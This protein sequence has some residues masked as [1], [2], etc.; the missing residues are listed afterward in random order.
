MTPR[1]PPK[2]F[3]KD[4]RNRLYARA[5]TRQQN[6]KAA[7]FL[8]D[9]LRDDLADRL[10]FMQLTPKNVL[11]VGDHT[12]AIGE[13]LQKSGVD[14][15]QSDPRNFDEELP[16]GT[17]I[18][19]TIID[20]GTIATVNDL[21]AALIHYHRALSQ[22]GHLFISLIGAGS[23][24]Q[25]RAAMLASE[26]DRAAPHIHPMIDSVTASALLSRAGFTRQVVSTYPLQVSYRSLGQLVSDLR[27]QGLGNAL[28]TIAD[29]LGKTAMRRA[30]QAFLAN[31]DQRQR[32]TETFNILSLTG[33]KS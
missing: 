4:R 23:V 6:A 31:A 3:S 14:V 30:E 17:E 10:A 9:D 32:V 28:T 1:P 5:L 7:R 15:K 16:H 2:I 11:L 25:L 29:P 13:F 12:G 26:P 24:P 21:P 8:S 33:W 27:D 19:D 22:G 18:Y 20:C